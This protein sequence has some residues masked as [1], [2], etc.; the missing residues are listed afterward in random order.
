MDENAK[1][2]SVETRNCNVRGSPCLGFAIAG[3]VYAYSR[4][5]SQAINDISSEGMCE[6]SATSGGVGFIGRFKGP[7]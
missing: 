1:E 3:S 5:E 2:A 4:G 7:T 6:N